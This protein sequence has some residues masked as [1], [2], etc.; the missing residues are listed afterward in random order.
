M[1]RELKGR[2]IDKALAEGEVIT[3]N[4]GHD[5]KG[6]PLA[7]T[8][9]ADDGRGFFAGEDKAAEEQKRLWHK[10]ALEYDAMVDR[11]IDELCNPSLA[12]RRRMEDE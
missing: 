5:D 2:Q 10:E 1:I 8:F 4:M 6:L 11:K 7:E 9:Y 12:R 3:S